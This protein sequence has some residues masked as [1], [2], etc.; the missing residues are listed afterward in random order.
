MPG[1]FFFLLKKKEIGIGS[2]S[3]YVGCTAHR[4]HPPIHP[5]YARTHVRCHYKF[6]MLPAFRVARFPFFPSSLTAGSLLLPPPLSRSLFLL[7]RDEKEEE[8]QR[9]ALPLC[10]EEGKQKGGK[11]G[12]R[13]GGGG[14][15]RG[16]A[17]G[18]REITGSCGF[19]QKSP[20]SSA[21]ANKKHAR[22]ERVNKQTLWLYLGSF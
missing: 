11:E 13:P 3:T 4:Q 22:N 21:K 15:R 18:K 19:R 6:P 12:R 9:G 1:L 7:P 10:V 17:N 16:Y 20:F 14:G 5:Q 2:T 8:G